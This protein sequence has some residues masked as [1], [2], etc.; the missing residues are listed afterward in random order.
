MWFTIYPRSTEITY[1]QGSEIIDNE[2]RESLIEEEYKIL[3]NP[4]IS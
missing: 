2:F 3:A 1:E 4:S